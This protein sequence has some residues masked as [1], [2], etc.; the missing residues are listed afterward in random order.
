MAAIFRPLRGSRSWGVLRSAVCLEVLLPHSFKSLCFGPRR[1]RL[2]P[3]RAALARR[4]GVAAFAV[5]Q[6]L[7][8]YPILIQFLFQFVFQF[9]FTVLLAGPQETSFL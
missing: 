2:S 4:G 3:R 5:S 8:H 6:F 9:L 1:D 7:F